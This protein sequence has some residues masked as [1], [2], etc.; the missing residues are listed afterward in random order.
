MLKNLGLHFEIFTPFTAV[1]LIT[2]A[3]LGYGGKFILGILYEKP[4]EKAVLIVK[5]IGLVLAL[6]GI[7]I[8][9][10]R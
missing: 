10:V 2:G 3:V 9:F 8:I 1:L 4:S 7:I 6:T 5:V